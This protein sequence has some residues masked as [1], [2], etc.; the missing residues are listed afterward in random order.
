[1]ITAT[2]SLRGHCQTNRVSPTSLAARSLT[3]RSQK[4]SPETNGVPGATN[5]Q[6]IIARKTLTSG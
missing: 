4:Q 6:P 3:E 5:R 2:V 1:M